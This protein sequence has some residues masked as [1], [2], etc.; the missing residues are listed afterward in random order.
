MDIV[1]FQLRKRDFLV[2]TQMEDK[3]FFI[4]HFDPVR[5]GTI[6]LAIKRIKE[7]SIPGNFA[8]VGVWQG[9]TSRII[10]SLAPEKPYYLF[11]TFEGFSKR[12]LDGRH[13]DRFAD[14]SI[15]FVKNIIGS[16]D[17]LIFRKGYFPE[18]SIGLE[19]ETFSFVMLD[20]DLYNPTLAGLEFFYPRLNPGGY[21]FIHDYNTPESDFAVSKAVNFFFKD[22]SE[23]IFELPDMFGT[24]V[25]RKS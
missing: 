23:K 8:E 25:V 13:D 15:E 17:N 4:K 1:R 14:T 10:H 18:T 24:V 12:D 9:R 2:F 21:L 5:Y 3:N 19:N 6:G 7:E 22:K 20:V 16:K 11:D